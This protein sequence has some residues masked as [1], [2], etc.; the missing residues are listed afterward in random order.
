[1]SSPHKEIVILAKLPDVDQPAGHTLLN[2]KYSAQEIAQ[3]NIAFLADTILQFARA[4]RTKS[5]V[6]SS[7]PSTPETLESYFLSPIEYRM[8]ERGSRRS[9]LAD[10]IESAFRDDHCRFCLLLLSPHPLIGSSIVENSIRMLSLE[11]E[12]I[13]Y[14]G[15]SNG[16][17]YLLGMK[18]AHAEFSSLA[19]CDFGDCGRLLRQCCAID[20]G[21]QTL[22]TLPVI[23]SFADLSAVRMRIE[24]LYEIRTEYPRKS[25]SCMRQLDE[26]HSG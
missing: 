11:D 5:I 1:M 10:S 20:G 15:L 8:V 25:L 19:D 22:P 21:V 13:V 24:H 3:L 23:R 26:S 2:G 17:P 7:Q 9:L 16:D 14:G 6:F 12:T 18:S 4:G